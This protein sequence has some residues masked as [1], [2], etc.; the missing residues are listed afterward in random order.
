M[1]LPK[2]E[3]QNPNPKT[4]NPTQVT[5][6]W[7]ASASS[8]RP[9]KVRPPAGSIAHPKPQTLNPKPTQHR[10]GLIRCGPRL[11]WVVQ[12]AGGPHTHTRP[13]THAHA[14]RYTHTN[15]GW[16]HARA[17]ACGPA[18]AHTDTHTNAGWCQIHTPTPGDTHTPTPGGARYTHTPT[19]GGAKHDNFPGPS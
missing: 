7:S 3:T 9:T 8:Y 12:G 15:A 16:W 6:A 14:H 10:A 11:F 2:F 1:Q 19:P 4:P 17:G 5:R 18:G 13:H